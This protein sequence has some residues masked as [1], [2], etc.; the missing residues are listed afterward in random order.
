[1]KHSHWDSQAYEQADALCSAV[2]LERYGMFNECQWDDFNDYDA[3][4][5]DWTDWRQ[6]EEGDEEITK[7][8]VEEPGC[9][10]E[11]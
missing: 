1:M 3:E 2:R 6:W 11:D 7:F 5:F 4:D 9:E 8:Q 10:E